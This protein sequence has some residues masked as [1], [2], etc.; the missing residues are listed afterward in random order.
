MK[1][2]FAL[3]AAAVFAAAALG[4]QQAAS[5]AEE[6]AIVVYFSHTGNTQSVA[7]TVA[8]LTGADIFRLE[9]AEPYPDDYQ[10]IREI[11]VRQLEENARPALKAMPENLAAYDVVYLG[12]PIW[13]HTIPAPV[14]TFLDNAGLAGKTVIPF[15]THGGG[16]AGESTDAIKRLA[17]K[18]TVLEDK[19]FYGGASEDEIAGWLDG[20]KK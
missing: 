13:R 6:K 15:C 17:P 11:A 16:G 20:L 1:K 4:T 3:I 19:E 10:A 9:T 18:A 2:I 12:H 14:K 7:E 5:A 8:R